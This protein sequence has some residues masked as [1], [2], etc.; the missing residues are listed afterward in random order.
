MLLIAHRA[1]MDGPNPELENHPDQ[2]RKVLDQNIHVEI[3]VWLNDSGWWLGHDQPQYLIGHGFLSLPGMWIHA[4]NFE[5][6][7]RLLQL[8]RFGH[9][10]NF[11]WHENDQRTLTSS[12]YWWTYPGQQLDTTSV[13]VMPEMHVGV[14]NIRSVLSWNCYGVCSDW[15]SRLK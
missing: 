10:L 2:I 7:H 11:F 13:A 4:K 15:I 12:G 9:D 5:A 8:T 6:A 3:D 14:D 1:L